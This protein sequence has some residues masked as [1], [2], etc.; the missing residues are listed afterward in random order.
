LIDVL[1]EE[2]NKMFVKEGREFNASNLWELTKLVESKSAWTEWTRQI[3]GAI[4]DT[5]EQIS[6]WLWWDYGKIAKESWSKSDILQWLDDVLW[7]LTRRTSE[8]WWEIAAAD[9]WGKVLK[10]N[11]RELLSQAKKFYPEIDLNKEIDS[12]L[13]HLAIYDPEKAAELAKNIYPSLPWVLE[14]LI[15][16]GKMIAT[17]RAAKDIVQKNAPEV[18]QKI[19]VWDAI[20]RSVR[21]K[22]AEWLVD[23]GQRF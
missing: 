4:K 20:W 12:W 22:T 16:G 3:V 5:M 21:W 10:W 6:E 18:P 15:N 8:A 1:K 19:S 23:L 7:K 13:I 11:L 9:A 17:K 14:L 2:W